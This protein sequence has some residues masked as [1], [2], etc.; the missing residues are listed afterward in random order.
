MQ[1]ARGDTCAM[2]GPLGIFAQAVNTG[3]IAAVILY[4]ILTGEHAA[5]STGTGHEI[6]DLLWFAVVCGLASFAT[7]EILKRVFRLRSLYQRRYIRAW[8]AEGWARAAGEAEEWREPHGQGRAYGEMLDAM[9]ARKEQ[10]SAVFDLPAEQLA[11]LIS[12]AADGAV[13]ERMYLMFVSALTGV[14]P[15]ALTEEY[16]AR[17]AAEATD[18]AD[19]PQQM[20]RLRLAHR[21]STGI[22]QLQIALSQS[23]RRYVQSAALWIAGGYGIALAHPS[24]GVAADAEARYVLV[25]LI[26]GGI[27]AWVAR[28]LA[29]LVEHARR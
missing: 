2:R 29:A 20:S 25:A 15:K 7:I 24:T 28:D 12:S 5:L 13:A 6:R 17:A 8:M 3:A 14:H 9:G 21:V 27:F 22:D 1:R 19:A 11:S 23:W 16:G 10:L 26:V 18:Q 4:A